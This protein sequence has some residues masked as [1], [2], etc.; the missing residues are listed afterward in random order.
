MSLGGRRT[1][2][3]GRG[4]RK[5]RKRRLNHSRFLDAAVVP[6][7]IWPLLLNLLPFGEL[8][9]RTADAL[10]LLL[11]LFLCLLLH[12]RPCDV[13]LHCHTAQVSLS[14]V[15]RALMERKENEEA[16]RTRPAAEQA[17][18]RSTDMGTGCPVS[19]TPL[20]KP[21]STHQESIY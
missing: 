12:R 1:A 21:S 18:G 14:L 5:C 2:S 4:R 10:H 6:T 11:L 3:E 17:G 13:R 7:P 8:R 15:A 16:A 19:A 20:K 9:R